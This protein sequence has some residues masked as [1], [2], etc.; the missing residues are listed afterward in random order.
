MYVSLEESIIVPKS[1]LARNSNHERV[2]KNPTPGE[3]RRTG[4]RI[5]GI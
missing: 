3:N 4:E 5:K 1:F 2:K